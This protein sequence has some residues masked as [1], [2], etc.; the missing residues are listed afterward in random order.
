[1]HHAIIG[2]VLAGFVLLT[3]CDL[4][5]RVKQDTSIE[6]IKPLVEERLI[7]PLGQ[8][9]GDQFSLPEKQPRRQLLQVRYHEKSLYQD[10]FLKI[11]NR[12][13]EQ[14]TVPKE[15]STAPS[16]S[17]ITDVPLADDLAGNHTAKHIPAI[18]NI[19]KEQFSVSRKTLR[20]NLIDETR[21]QLHQQKQAYSA[22]IDAALVEVLLD[23]DADIRVEL[24][25]LTDQINTI[26]TDHI[27]G[28]AATL[29]DQVFGMDLTIDQNGYLSLP[30]HLAFLGDGR[31]GVVSSK[32]GHARL[33]LDNIN[34]SFHFSNLPLAEAIKLVGHAAGMQMILSPTVASDETIVKFNIEAGAIS[35]LDALFHQYGI[36]IIYDPEL[37]V[38][39]IYTDAEFETRLNRISKAI[40]SHNANHHRQL[41]IDAL[42][43]QHQ[44]L[45]VLLDAIRKHN[46]ATTNS[47]K[48]QTASTILQDL[49]VADTSKTTIFSNRTTL[50]SWLNAA[51]LMAN[52]QDN[53]DL[54]ASDIIS[55]NPLIQSARQDMIR[56][57]QQLTQQLKQFDAE[58]VAYLSGQPIPL[59]EPVIHQAG[60][61][62]Y[63]GA[64]AG[65]EHLAIKDDCITPSREIF[66]EKVA[67]YGGEN[68]MIRISTILDSYFSDKTAPQSPKQIND[69]NGDNAITTYDACSNQ[70]YM[71]GLNYVQANDASGYVVTGY[72]EDIELLVRLVEQFDRPQRQVLIEV[73]MI[74]VVKDFNRKLDLTFQTDALASDTSQTGGFFLRRDLTDLSQ[75]VTSQTPG[76][77]VSGLISPNNQVEAL[78]DFIETNN[79][80]QTISSPTILV[81]EG[82]SASVTRTNTKPVTRISQQT[83]LDSNNNLIEVPV[84]E[85]VEESVS[86]T[87]DVADIKINPNNN[88]VTLKFAL[89]DQSFET[90]LANV[91]ATTGKTEDAINTSFVAAPGDVIILAGLFKQIDT[92]AAAGLPGTTRTNLPT[93]FLLGGEDQITN[94]TE[95]MIILMAP[96]VIEP[97]I[98]RKSPHSALD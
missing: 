28:I 64:F 47:R 25:R 39:Q 12:L 51:I 88:N 70:T 31:D 27:P 97:E 73:Y 81:E 45:Q 57:Q 9:S 38:A 13:A 84:S 30:P 3:G 43:T 1:M 55:P 86:F 42:N 29:P 36:S 20:Q 6:T 11:L 96:T 5:N 62:N 23:L 16:A 34:H 83:L 19:E 74:N 40:E 24:S 44:A 50:D 26:N 21:L 93:A 35:A 58:T 67:V 10:G 85:T 22:Q 15:I 48:S 77:F 75:S 4:P 8:A 41:Q 46:Y 61:R 7:A 66:T 53:P 56:S 72:N 63:V 54:V 68:A 91:D 98:G 76:G 94:K 90:T 60:S 78:V 82:G 18:S 87:L 79:L 80:G 65:F 59:A 92:T 49:Q 17:T 33:H 69:Q 52:W 32:L 71:T 95:E 37:E 14:E 2:C 89:K